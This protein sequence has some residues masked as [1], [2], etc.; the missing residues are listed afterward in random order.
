MGLR[1]ILKKTGAIKFRRSI[2]VNASKMRE[3]SAAGQTARYFR[4]SLCK[5]R[6]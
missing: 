4:E 5:E 3:Q 6:E 2:D 1:L